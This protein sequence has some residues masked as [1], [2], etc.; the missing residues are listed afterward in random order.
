MKIGFILEC[1]PGGSDATVYKYVAQRLCPALEIEKPQTLINKPGVFNEGPA[2]IQTL[3][4]GGCDYV[5]V[6]WD[7]K[8]RFLLP[9]NC[10][11][12]IQ[13]FT[14]SLNQLN[15]NTAQVVICC[16][17]EMLES[18]LIADGRGFDRWLQLKTTHRLANFGDHQS[19]AE[20]S[21]P[22]N[23]IRS[24]LRDNYGVWKYNESEDNLEIV[25][26]LPDFNRA[27]RLND[28]FRAFKEKIEEIC[29]G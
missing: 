8:P 3:L 6:I 13:T 23:R 9:G 1:Q 5:F 22:K 2:V 27:A 16:I 7:R 28:S 26:H 18:W 29:P 19:R 17:D 21:D 14:D 11:T 24:F 10:Q 25:K 20:Q 12:D 15:I 4:A